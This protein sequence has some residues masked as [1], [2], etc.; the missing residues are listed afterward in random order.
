MIAIG[1][2]FIALGLV[3]LK[4]GMLGIRRYHG[5]SRLGRWT[6]AL[7]GFAVWPQRYDRLA[8]VVQGLLL[9]GIG[10]GIAFNR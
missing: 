5:R 2:I 3:W 8:V 4:F 9:I 1:I 7:G 6:S 10:I